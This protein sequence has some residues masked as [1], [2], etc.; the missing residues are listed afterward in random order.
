VD[1]QLAV[2]HF[3]QVLVRSASSHGAGRLNGFL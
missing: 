1:A 2:E 3:F